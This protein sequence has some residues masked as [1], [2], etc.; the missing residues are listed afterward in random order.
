MFV[1]DEQPATSSANHSDACAILR[2]IG[3]TLPVMPSD[4][5]K[6]RGGF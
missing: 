1:L 6:R 4:A 5:G 3:T 2:L